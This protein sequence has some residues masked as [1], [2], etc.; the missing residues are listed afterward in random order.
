MGRRGQAQRSHGA[1]SNRSATAGDIFDSSLQARLNKTTAKVTKSEVSIDIIRRQGQK[2]IEQMLLQVDNLTNLSEEYLEKGLLG[3]H[4]EALEMR[5]A[6]LEKLEQTRKKL[7]LP[8][9]EAFSSVASS[10]SPM[11]SSPA[12]SSTAKVAPAASKASPASNSAGTVPSPP[13][14]STAASSTASSANSGAKSASQVPSVPGGREVVP[15]RTDASSTPPPI[16]D[17]TSAAALDAAV[18][19][20]AGNVDRW[21]SLLARGNQV[22]S[23]HGSASTSPICYRWRKASDEDAAGSPVTLEVRG[24][25]ARLEVDVSESVV[26]LRWPSTSSDSV[27]DG[28]RHTVRLPLGFQTDPDLCQAVRR[29]KA[30]ELSLSFPRVSSLPS[31]VACL[32]EEMKGEDGIGCIDGLMSAC[33]LDMIRHKILDMWK[34][35]RLDPGEVEGGEMKKVRSDKYLFLED[36]DDS[37]IAKFTKQLDT[38]V[39]QLVREVPHLKR[40]K[41]LRGR[42]MAAVYSDPGARYVPHY[43]CVRSDNGRVL[44]VILYLNPFWRE[45]D[46]AQ[47]S[48]WPEVRPLSLERRGRSRQID[49][50]HG[51]LVAWLCDSRNLHEVLPLADRDT[52]EPRVALSCWYYDSDLLPGIVAREG[53]L[54]ADAPV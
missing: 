38:A 14:T 13:N 42:P 49:P 5:D 45:A 25:T 8:A 47:L 31:Q 37:V 48:L 35:G 7:G 34:A 9:G 1:N 10:A 19:S 24:D 12:V 26:H 46:G 18:S 41:L 15:Q 50:I 54:P 16:P 28:H 53:D 40:L 43:D 33:E 23:G 20:D 3:H 21:T 32:A 30:D 27:N 29:R 17:T 51:R 2:C 11:L 52:V 39:L 44:T 6:A 36:R 22:A 4:V